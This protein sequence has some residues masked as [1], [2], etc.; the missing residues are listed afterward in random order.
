MTDEEKIQPGKSASKAFFTNP[1]S[2]IMAFVAL[3]SIVFAWG[4]KSEKKENSVSGLKQDI[5]DIRLIVAP[6]KVQADTLYNMLD[7]HINNQII[8]SGVINSN[9][10]NAIRDLGNLKALV[11][12]EFA[13]SMTP[14]QVNEMWERF[15]KK[16]LN[17]IQSDSTSKTRYFG[18]LK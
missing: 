1:A 12:S 10:E 2:Y 4:V 18:I 7:K 3:G 17:Q 15:E 6:L 5:E 11:T 13:K 8:S 14:T 16:N 9:V